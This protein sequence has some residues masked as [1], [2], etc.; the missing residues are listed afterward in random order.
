MS[1]TNLATLQNAGRGPLT[2]NIDE[3]GG[4][5]ETRSGLADPDV[6]LH[7]GPAIFAGEG[8]GPPPT[9]HGTVIAVSTLNPESRGS[10]SLRS[11]APDTAQ[12]ISHNYLQTE[13]DRL[14]MI[15]GLRAALEIA[16][17][18][19]MRKVITG[20]FDVPESDSDA[21]LLAHVRRTAQTHYHPASTCAIG[22]VVGNDHAVLGLD[23]LRVVDASVM[24]TVTRGNINAPTIMIAEKAAD[25]I[26]G[27][28]YR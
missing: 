17:R 14:T 8:L 10:V 22:S 27:R 13:Q 4:H 18:P 15:A 23:G 7:N 6:Q 5:L 1:P 28:P 24:P 11:A 12:R 2:S 19:A 26:R 25:I 9:V 21:D 20:Q 3:A 16:A